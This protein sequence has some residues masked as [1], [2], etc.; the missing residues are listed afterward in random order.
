MGEY[1]TCIHDCESALKLLDIKDDWFKEK[2]SDTSISYYIHTLYWYWNALT[3]I[4]DLPKANLFKY[5][6]IDT[7]ANQQLYFA[8]QYLYD[9]R[10]EESLQ[11]LELA[12]D[13]L[14]D[15]SAI[16]NSESVEPSN[17]LNSLLENFDSKR[18]SVLEKFSVLK[19]FN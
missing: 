3:Q 15:C 4:N 17:K 9:E 2:D 8:N 16:Y 10:F 7:L 19:D 18:K 13:Y 11:C 14:N 12:L 6:Y 1:Y 5:F